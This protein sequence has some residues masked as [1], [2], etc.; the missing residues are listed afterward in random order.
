MRILSS[1]YGWLPIIFLI[2]GKCYAAGRDCI[3]DDVMILPKDGY[4][5]A[6]S[7]DHRCPM[8]VAWQIRK[9]DLSGKQSRRSLSFRTDYSTPAPRTRSRD[10]VR[11]G[12]DR[13]HMCPAAD[14]KSSITRYR[15][16]FIMTN[17][18]PMCPA[19][20]RGPWKVTEDIARLAARR[21]GLVHARCGISLKISLRPSRVCNT[22]TSGTV[23]QEQISSR[24][25]IPEW[26]E[27]FIPTGFWKII[28]TLQPDTLVSCWVFANDSTC[29]SAG[30]GL[31][32]LDSLRHV[33]DSAYLPPFLRERGRQY[34][35]LIKF[36]L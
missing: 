6:Y 32:S 23:I 25:T 7:P 19:L 9:S 33:A 27:L 2:S 14:R 20:N 16:T 5:I 34:K 28:Y 8:A 17:V 30:A 12:Y 22:K 15:A 18:A 3:H 13:G 21:Y 26:P 4:A 10:Y 11:S 29:L 1:L 35:P 31:V 36:D 24:I